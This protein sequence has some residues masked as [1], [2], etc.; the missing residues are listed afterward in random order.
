MRTLILM[1]ILEK[2]RENA[3]LGPHPNEKAAPPRK[4]TQLVR[5]RTAMTVVEESYE[6]SQSSMK[7]MESVDVED[8]LELSKGVGEVAQEQVPANKEDSLEYSVEM[9]PATPSPSSIYSPPKD[10]KPSS[11]KLLV[12]FLLLL[13]NQSPIEM[14]PFS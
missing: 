13:P 8:S 11:V 14:Q 1:R 9:Q 10:P 6:S 5:G 2:E 3:R 12:H 7:P 4:S